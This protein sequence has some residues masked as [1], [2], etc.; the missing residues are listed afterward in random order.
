MNFKYKC[1]IIKVLSIGY[2]TILFFIFGYFFGYI[3]DQSCL[4]LFGNNYIHKSTYL[5][6]FEVLVQVVIL[7]IMMHI[8]RCIIMAIPF[9]LNGIYGFKYLQLNELISGTFLSVFIMLFQYNMQDKILY[10]NKRVNNIKDNVEK[11][12]EKDVKI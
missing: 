1:Q 4:R 5:L 9:P 8:G 10:I 2:T 7:G 12:V 3:L 6:I 11:D